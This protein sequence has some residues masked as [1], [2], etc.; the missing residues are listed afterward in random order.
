ML[1]RSQ[2]KYAALATG[3]L[4]CSALVYLPRQ[5]DFL[6]WVT[7]GPMNT[8]HEA[9]ECTKCH[10]EAKGSTRQQ[11]QAV[12][13]Q[14]IGLRDGEVHVGTL[15]VRDASCQHCHE[16]PNDRHPIYR[17]R[18]PRFAE[19]RAAIGADR[20]ISCHREHN[21]VRVTQGVGICVNCHQD[22]RLKNDPL[23]ESHA[24][25]IERKAWDSCLSCHD[26]HGNHEYEVPS[27]MSDAFESE[28][29][30]RYLAGQTWLYAEEA[31][32]PAKQE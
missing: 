8:G 20:C 14:W 1:T 13:R 15:P 22:T 2:L 17:F 16:R 3:L 28:R 25:L 10:L 29:V 30:A 24:A 21:G 11:I 32:H 31:I 4:L 12:A 9:L 26:F 18:E 5:G 7:P 19:A 6:R 27:R 23:D